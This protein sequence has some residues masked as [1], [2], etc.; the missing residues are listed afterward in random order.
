MNW[1]DALF[2]I[3]GCEAFE[4]YEDKVSGDYFVP[5][6]MN[7]ALEYYLILKRAHLVGEYCSDQKIVSAKIVDDDQGY[8]LVLRQEDENTC[9]LYFEDVE[10]KASCYQYHSIGHFW[11]QGAEQWRQLVYII[12]TIYDKYEYF[13]ER[14]CNEK[15]LEIM[16]LIR[17][18][19]F[20]YWSPIKES[21]EERYPDSK[22]GWQSMYRLVKESDDNGF[23]KLMWIYYF[24]RSYSLEKLISKKFLSPKRQKLY[25]TI[26]QKVQEAS[27]EYP[28]RD[29]GYALNSEME[30]K[31]KEVEKMLL[32]K[33][34]V[35][36]YPEYKKGNIQ[37]IATEEHPFTV[38][39]NKD[40]VFKIQLMMSKCSIPNAGRN[41]G[42][43]T[44]KGRKG[45]ISDIVSILEI[46]K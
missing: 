12:G 8:V 40:Y 20:R 46:D 4:L 3:I 30:D 11:V 43:F 6:M 42:F 27:L 28:K 18:G 44:G 24:F 31:R 39:E 15:E 22:E 9:T 14:F 10:E 13:G 7:D 5:Y 21:L 23:K 2:D 1:V 17:F 33:G 29:Y 36:H 26:Y 25:E 32:N 19:P 16:N 34:Y 38:M 45:K 37:V 41:A 35:G